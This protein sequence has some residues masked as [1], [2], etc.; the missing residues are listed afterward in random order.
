MWFV[1][2]DKEE[3]QD[4][5]QHIEKIVFIPGKSVH[6]FNQKS[7]MKASDQIKYLQST[8]KPLYFLNYTLSTQHNEI[9]SAIESSKYTRNSS[10]D[11]NNDNHN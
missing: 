6:F 9:M 3:K 10:N 4:K 8:M 1:I 5:T 2:V 11:N 7:T